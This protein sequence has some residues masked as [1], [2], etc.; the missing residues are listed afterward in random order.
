MTARRAAGFTLV[1]LLV[2]LALFALIGMAGFSML[3]QVLRTQRQTE[4]RLDRLAELQRAMY[5]LTEDFSQATPRSF[6]AALPPAKPGA[7]EPGIAVRLSRSAPAA[8]TGSVGLTYALDGDTLVRTVEGAPARRQPLVRGVAAVDWRFLDATQGW[9]ET[10]P[11]LQQTAAAGAAPENPDAAILTLT[12]A[13]GLDRQI[14]RVLL[15][16]RGAP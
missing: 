10:W 15:L 11:P 16:P 14:R 7:P 4:G 1:E 12:L 5:L 6:A 3:D 2:A 8:E 13:E 9:I